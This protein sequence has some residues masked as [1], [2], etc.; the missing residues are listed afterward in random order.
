M[1]RV[2]I[3]LDLIDSSVTG[4]YMENLIS[5]WCDRGLTLKHAAILA[6]VLSAWTKRDDWFI[7]CL[8]KEKSV[9]E[10]MRGRIMQSLDIWEEVPAWDEVWRLKLAFDRDRKIDW[11]PNVKLYAVIVC[12]LLPEMIVEVSD[13][14]I[15]YPALLTDFL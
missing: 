12:K 14:Q 10:E 5:C 11:H 9:F 3:P 1:S 13:C 4:I 2:R 8:E 7:R 15:E 6:S